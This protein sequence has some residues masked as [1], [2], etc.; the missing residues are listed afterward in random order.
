MKNLFTLSLLVIA[1]SASVFCQP[2]QAFK[3][4]A[5][6]RDIAGEILS[7]PAVDVRVTIHDQTPGGGIVYQET[8]SVT[9]NQFGLINL[10][11]GL[12]TPVG[13]YNFESIDWSADSKFIEIEID[14]LGGGGY[15]SMGTSELFSVPYALY[16]ERAS[17]GVWN[18]SG[19]NLYYDGGFVGIGTSAPY[20]DLIVKSSGYTHGMY[21]LADDE[22][23]LFR[24]R[25]NSDGSGG[26]YLYDESGNSQINFNASF[27]SYINGGN[28][29]IGHTSPLGRLSIESPSGNYP[30]FSPVKGLVIKDGNFNTGSDLEIQRSD[31]NVNFI[32]SDAGRVGIGVD[33]PQAGLHVK[34]GNWPSSYLYL[35]SDDDA[36]AGIRLYEGETAQ[37]H[38]FNNSAADGLHIYNA[39]GSSTVFY[40]DQVTGSVGIGTVAPASGYRLSVDGKV[41]CE[42]VL[43]EYSEGWP[44]FVFSEDYNLLSLEDLEKQIK[45]NNRLPGIPSAEEVKEN[46]FHLA[47]MQKQVLEKVE[48]L[49]LYTIEQGKLIDNLQKEMEA[50][51]IENKALRKAIRSQ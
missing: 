20:T 27:D 51:K 6:V 7:N 11:I 40:A 25:Q 13:Y 9:T 32:V 26:I 23:K 17:G 1:I 21:V 22:D 5:V 15:V 28:L 48:E 19:S 34:G 3:Y 18:S 37:W 16:S 14:D 50:I 29:S 45:E 4:Q 2:P 42:E 36:D 24:V 46:G 31:G 33:V 35:Q 8:H 41:A 47:E 10:N 49:T 30:I 43:V 39:D 44:D 38:I 12:G